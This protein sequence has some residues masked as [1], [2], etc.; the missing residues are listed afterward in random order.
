[1]EPVT[2]PDVVC[3]LLWLRPTAKV[4]SQGGWIEGADKHPIPEVPAGLESDYE[5]GRREASYD[6][7][8]ALAAA[9]DFDPPAEYP[10]EPTKRFWD[11]V[12]LAVMST[13]KKIHLMEESNRE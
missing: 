9:L 7:A 11:G 2:G 8:T 6:F 1:M 5:R 10:D 12:K 3:H 13:M 4:I